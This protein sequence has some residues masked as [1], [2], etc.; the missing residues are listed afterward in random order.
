MASMEL[1]PLFLKALTLLRSKSR[2]STDQ[3]K[4]LLDEVLGKKPKGESGKTDRDSDEKLIRKKEEK[5]GKPSQSIKKLT[6]MD[7]RKLSTKRPLEKK[8]RD[9]RTTTTMMKR[10]RKQTKIVVFDTEKKKSDVINISSDSEDS[11]TDVPKKDGGATTGMEEEAAGSTNMDDFALELGLACVVCK[12]MDVSAKNQL[13]ECQECHNLYHQFCHKPAAVDT[14]ANDPRL[15]WY[16]AKCQRNMRKSDFTFRQPKLR[17]RQETFKSSSSLVDLSSSGSEKKS[18]EQNMNLFKRSEPKTP[19]VSSVGKSQPFTGF[20]A[21]A[22]NVSGKNSSSAKSSSV[23]NKPSTILG[24]SN[25]RVNMSG[26]PTKSSSAGGS[27]TVLSKFKSASSESRS[28]SPQ[29]TTGSSKGKVGVVKNL[30]QAS[31]ASAMKRLQ[32]MKKKASK[33]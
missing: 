6:S 29:P 21:Y 24:K 10:T 28:P 19:P 1:D 12:K 4:A 2:E 31:Q 22:A 13:I 11:P 14:D 27:R 16:C 15:V 32:Q 33:R 9:R 5:E 8:T 3:L 25:I 18:G 23:S 20:A 30:P 7:E 26:G 17:G